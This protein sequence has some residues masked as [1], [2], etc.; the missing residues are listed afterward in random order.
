MSESEY[1]CDACE[2]SFESEEALQEHVEDAGLA[3]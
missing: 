3:N 2:E 1:T